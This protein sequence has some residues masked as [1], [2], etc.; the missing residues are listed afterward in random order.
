[1]CLV[2]LNNCQPNNSDAMHGLKWNGMRVGEEGEERQ[3]RANSVW[4][5]RHH[6]DIFF[7]LCVG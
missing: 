7:P 3:G 4:E 5:G 2:L 6:T 1:M